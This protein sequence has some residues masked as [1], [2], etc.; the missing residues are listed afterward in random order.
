MKRNVT[1]GFGDGEEDLALSAELAALL[2]VW[3]L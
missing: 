2:T 1:G 3:C